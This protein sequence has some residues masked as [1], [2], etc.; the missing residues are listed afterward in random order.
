VLHHDC[1]AIM[2]EVISLPIIL[3]CFS[4]PSAAPTLVTRS[5][6]QIWAFATIA[7]S[8]VKNEARAVEL[9]LRAIALGSAQAIKNL[10]D[11]YYDSTGVAKDYSEAVRLFKQAAELG[12]PWALC[13]LGVCYQYGQGVAKDVARARSL[14]QEA[15]AL[16]NQ[17]A[18]R[19][20]AALG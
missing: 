10:G 18:K 19:N 6:R 15:A 3:I 13:N 20:L 7:E 17:L 12:N 11:C 1:K 2:F 9:Y 4:W 5:P 16:G 8:V 14:Y